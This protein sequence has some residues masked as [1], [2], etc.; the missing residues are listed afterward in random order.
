VSVNNSHLQYL[1]QKYYLD[2]ETYESFVSS[3]WEKMQ[4]TVS[5]EMDENNYA[6][7][8]G[9]GF[10]YRSHISSPAKMLSWLTIMSYLL[11]LKNTKE[12]S[13]LIP[14][15]LSL[16]KRIEVPFTYDCF[17][18][19]CTFSLLRRHASEGRIVIIGDGFGYLAAFIKM[20]WP[21][22]QIFLIDI[23]KILFFQAYH[24]QK[25]FPDHSH[26]LSIDAG[27]RTNPN[28]ENADF[29]FC[30]AEHTTSLKQF[31]FDVAINVA[32][33]QEMNSRTINEYF[34]FLRHTLK[35]KN[36]FYCCNRKKKIMPAGEISEFYKY[37]WT[38]G[39]RHLVDEPCP[40]HLFFW[41]FPN[42]AVGPQLLGWKVPFINYF[43]GLHLH[44]MTVLESYNS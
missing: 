13:R 32:S 40:W 2:T 4:E 39:D 29:I 1:Y 5:V 27:G 30:P 14:A 9:N 15:G 21:R 23:G 42:S 19:I 26:Q 24:C 41:G 16:S 20:M 8:S 3:H 36:I 37:P 11:R 12:L 22:S 17:R 31:K 44:R 38:R 7:L 18:Q 43:D 34:N 33:M 6:G 10:S 25:A 28:A 35:K